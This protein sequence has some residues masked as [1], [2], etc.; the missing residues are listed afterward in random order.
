MPDCLGTIITIVTGKSRND[1]RHSSALLSQRQVF[2]PSA[3]K[4]G[5]PYGVSHVCVVVVGVGDW[6]EGFN[7]VVEVSPVCVWGV[8]GSGITLS[9]DGDHVTEGAGGARPTC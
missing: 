1:Y 3:T 2:G 4:S 8:G 9:R 6:E 7:P 5:R